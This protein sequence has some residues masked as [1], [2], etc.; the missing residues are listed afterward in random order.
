MPNLNFA[1]I[2]SLATSKAREYADRGSAELHYVRKMFEAGAL[3]LEPPQNVAA[4]VADLVRWG[5]VGMIPAVN[6]RRTP[7]RAAIIDDEG[8]M[9]FRELDDSANAVANCLVALGVR[10]ADGVAILARNHRWFSIAN[11]A[12]ARVGARTIMLNTEFSSRQIAEVA[13]REDARLL[14][15]DDEYTDAV[16]GVNLPLGRLR[17]LGQNPDKDKPSG[18]TDET[19][20][21]VIA[22]S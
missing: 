9:T 6:A 15:Y 2:A 19:L 13:E 7:H 22:R 10:G 12:C 11:Y 18:S 21:E 20:A 14:I 4:M 1:D 3:K 8:T 17:A 16:A 5:E